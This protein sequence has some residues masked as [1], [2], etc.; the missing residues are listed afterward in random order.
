MAL[1][2]LLRAN[3]ISALSLTDGP[4]FRAK[5]WLHG[6]LPL[7]DGAQTGAGPGRRHE[8]QIVWETVSTGRR[9]ESLPA[10][11]S[12][13]R[14][15]AEVPTP[16][17]FVRPLTQYAVRTSSKKHKGGYSHAVVFTSR[18]DLDMMGVVEHYDGRAVMEA[19]LKND[20]SGI[21]RL[22]QQVWAIPGR[23]KLTE[24]GV[25]RVRLRR[26]HPRARD[27]CSGFRS[28]LANSSIELVLD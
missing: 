7:Q 28:L 5:T 2:I 13:G 8:R 20:K 16:V 22:I 26:A 10:T 24:K 27:G 12:P 15:V 19:D 14:E 4:R 1:L 11:S 3:K 23:I 25:Q 17:A 9:V 18:T 21:V 6:T